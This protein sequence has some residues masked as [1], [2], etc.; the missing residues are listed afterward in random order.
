M[1]ISILASS[2]RDQYHSEVTKTLVFALVSQSRT[3]TA[4]M[5]LNFI[6]RSQHSPHW[7][8]HLCSQQ[9]RDSSISKFAL[10]VTVQLLLYT[11]RALPQLLVFFVSMPRRWRNDCMHQS[12]PHVKITAFHCSPYTQK[13]FNYRKY[14]IFLLHICV[15]FAQYIL[16]IVSAYIL[17]VL[18]TRFDGYFGF[19]SYKARMNVLAL[20]E[21]KSQCKY[22]TSPIQ[23]HGKHVQ[24]QSKL[25]K[26]G[27]AYSI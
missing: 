26:Q 3:C 15:P 11:K 9:R 16:C 12:L 1:I 19:G 21:Q 22:V 27:L 13:T 7:P 23:L 18:N 8:C 2:H 17:P 25:V 6:D 24:N 20:Y 5:N 14:N 4:W 10:N